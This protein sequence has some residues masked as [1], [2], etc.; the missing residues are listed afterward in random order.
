MH[1]RCKAWRIFCGKETNNMSEETQKPKA[2]PAIGAR[3]TR[4]RT[5]TDDDIV[6]FAEVSGDRNPVHLDADYA[7]R[8][9]FGQR[10]AHGFL[11]GS[12]ISALIGMELPGAGSIYLGQTLKFLAPVHIGDTVTAS[13]EVIGVREEKRII[14]LRTDCTNQD[15]ILVLTGEAVVKY[16]G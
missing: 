1:P 10:I 8:S 4:V 14:T 13:V 6:R 12:M 7:A 15:G 2:L 5:I 3:A 11:T 9:P 16:G